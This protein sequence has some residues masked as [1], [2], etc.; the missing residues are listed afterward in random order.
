M[1][2]IKFGNTYELL[3]HLHLKGIL[4]GYYIAGP[5]ESGSGAY[6]EILNTEIKDVLF[7]LFYENKGA[8]W[9]NGDQYYTNDIDL[10]IIDDEVIIIQAKSYCDFY[11]EIEG[12]TD[13]E[14]DTD[15]EVIEE[16]VAKDYIEFMVKYGHF[17]DQS[18]EFEEDEIK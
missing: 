5:N 2:K 1:A 8:C 12:N 9:D 13:S 11:D 15:K 4:K 7:E 10:K 18:Y 16:E 3:K 14:E 6:P 17:K